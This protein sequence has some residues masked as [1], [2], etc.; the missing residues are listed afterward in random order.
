MHHSKNQTPFLFQ[1]AVLYTKMSQVSL[2]L[3]YEY[4]TV[5][6][7]INEIPLDSKV[8]VIGAVELEPVR[9][10]TV[11]E[12]EAPIRE[13]HPIDNTGS[14]K[15]ALWREYTEIEAGQTYEFLRLI[16]VKF[17]GEIVLQSTTQTT[18][19][20]SS[21][22]L[23]NYEIPERNELNTFEN[24]SIVAIDSS[25]TRNCTICKAAAEPVGEKRI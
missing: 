5:Q 16:K 4:N 8:N 2:V 11:N 3:G 13:G 21:N 24:V 23:E 9:H 15:L 20:R 18:Y 1:T 25:D 10:V 22:Q 17:N 6:E 14:V 12:S 19:Q 7:V